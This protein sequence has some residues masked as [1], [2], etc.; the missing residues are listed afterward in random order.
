MLAF[1]C[2]CGHE[3]REQHQARFVFECAHARTCIHVITCAHVHTAT[4]TDR[5]A[6]AADMCFG[7][8]VDFLCFSSLKTKDIFIVG[9]STCP[10]GSVHHQPALPRRSRVGAML[11]PTPRN[12]RD[13]LLSWLALPR[14]TFRALFPPHGNVDL[15]GGTLL[16]LGS[17]PLRTGG[18]GGSS[19]PPPAQPVAWRRLQMHA[20]VARTSWEIDAVVCP[21]PIA[22]V[23]TFAA[24]RGFRG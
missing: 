17:L 6:R 11:I 5:I 13:A 20:G 12:L 4:E 23:R 15:L 19:D 14:V 7:V 18:G 3:K 8:L 22:H 1:V 16:H 24:S 2:K 10:A 21:I 9:S